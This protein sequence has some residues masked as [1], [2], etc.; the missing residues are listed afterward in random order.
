M[1]ITAQGSQ[2]FVVVG[3]SSRYNV[4]DRNW[5]DAGLARYSELYSMSL[6]SLIYGVLFL[7]RV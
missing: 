6:G 7:R 2:V 1:E 4:F 5:A 3:N